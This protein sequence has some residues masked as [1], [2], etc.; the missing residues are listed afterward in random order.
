M[1]SFTSFLTNKKFPSF[2]KFRSL[3]SG[4]FTAFRIVVLSTLIAVSA[5]IFA[6]LIMLNS[7]ILVTVPARGGTLTE[8]VIGAPHFINPILA[9]TETDKRLVALVYSTVADDMQSYT[10]SPDGKIYTVT[11][12]PNL[13]FDDKKPL[14][15]D[16][17]AFTVEKMQDNTIS[18][19]SNYWQN[20]AVDTPDVNTVVFT[21]P[22][23]DTSFLDHLNFGILPKHIWQNITDETFSAASQNLHPVGSGA[24]K[25]TALT[26]QDSIP[27][28]VILSRNNYAAGGTALLRGFTLATFANQSSLID[29]LNSGAIDFSYSVSPAALPHS[30]SRNLF[31]QSI[32]TDQTVSI[33]HA[34]SD[35]ALSNGTMVMMVNQNIDK[36]ALIAIVQHGYGTPAG[37]SS[38]NTTQK[39]TAS[40]SPSGFYVAV[41]NSPDMLLAAQTL[42]QQLQQQ[43]ITVAV[44]AFDPGTFQNNIT[45]GTFTIF[46]ARNGDVNIPEQYSPVLPLYTESVPYIF[47]QHAHTIIPDTLSSPA[48]E[49]SDVKNWYANTDKLWKWLIAKK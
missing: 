34:A 3:L 12:L 6:L 35:T 8:G 13:R 47:N 21:L 48:A 24:F 31:T 44:K 45:A 36:S 46:L 32:P 26:Y 9:T 19:Q 14:T 23:P 33:Y 28:T 7:K 43:G 10:V 30:L 4:P 5:I 2:K 22:A 41:E 29:A 27:T 39:N 18:T 15:S 1:A 42:A 16:D 40:L 11:L 49:Y 20:I 37:V 17:I 25:V 38:E